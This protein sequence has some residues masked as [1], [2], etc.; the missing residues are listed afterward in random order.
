MGRQV[1]RLGRDGELRTLLVLML[2][3]A[4]LSAFMNSGGVTALLLPVALDICRRTQRPP[5]QVLIP[6]SFS[7]LLGG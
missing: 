2:A 4:A 6:L 7:S 3:S 1:I 5:S